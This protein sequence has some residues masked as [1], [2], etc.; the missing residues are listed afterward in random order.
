MIEK[1]ISFTQ[2]WARTA[3]E[4]SC[5]QTNKDSLLI[6]LTWLNA[7]GIISDELRDHLKQE[8]QRHYDNYMGMLWSKYQNDD[9]ADED[10]DRGV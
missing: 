5:Y 10:N 2:T 1:I 3:A 8:Y 9:Q 6:T 7:A 4:L